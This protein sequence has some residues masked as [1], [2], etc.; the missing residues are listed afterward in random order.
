MGVEIIGGFP[1]PDSDGWQDTRCCLVCNTADWAFG[2]IFSDR[3]EAEG[4]LRWVE[5]AGYDDPRTW[6]DA[7]MELR[8]AEHRLH[9][10]ARK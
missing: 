4:F 2:P 8:V 1:D 3:A 5:D 6:S 10:E 9:K 7:L